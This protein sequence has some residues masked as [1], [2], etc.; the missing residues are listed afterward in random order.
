VSKFQWESLPAG[1]VTAIEEVTGPVVKAESATD[2]LMPGL[3]AVVHAANGHYFV[4]A[5]PAGSPAASLYQREMAASAALTAS[6]PALQ[7]LYSSGDGGWL[8]M[9]FDFLDARDADLSPS[10]PD[11]DGA[12]AA[13]A[14]IGAARA[15]G[16]VPLVIA[17]VTAL[18][19]KAAALLR[20]QPG[21][22][23]WDMY[24][25]AVEGFDAAALTGDQLVHYDL[26]PGN[27]K[28]TADGDV[29]A[30]DWAF[31]CAG[32][33]WIDV[34]FLMPRLIE[35][36]HSPASAERLASRL[37]AWRTAPATVV[38]ALAALWTMFREYKAVYGPRDAR[39]FR[40]R[41]AQAGR[42]WVEY[43]MG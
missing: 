8:V 27:L 11:L 3:A 9:L 17:N 25:A 19:E 33:P 40:E 28:V 35:A 34:A 42:S 37:P 24:R 16:G 26:H 15:P 6:V 23:L 12:L 43:R 36:G 30:V 18:Q 7:M 2:G 31:A 32:A 39:A 14:A 10:S 4:K 22:R 29:V 21:G 13:L 5:A 38:T 20:K 1:R 41:A